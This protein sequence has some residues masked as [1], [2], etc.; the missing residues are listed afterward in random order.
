MSSVTQQLLRAQKLAKSGKFSKAELIYKSLTAPPKNDLSAAV[1]YAIFL[2]KFERWNDLKALWQHA[3]SHP[4]ASVKM[5][6][7][8]ANLHL[9]LN[10]LTEATA[11]V[12]RIEGMN[13]LDAKV[14]ALRYSIAS[15][16]GKHQEALR[17]ALEAVK[18]EPKSVVGFVN[19]GVAFCD[20]A[21]LQQGETAFKIALELEPGNITAL[22]NLGFICAEQ[23]N[24]D[25]SIKYYEQALEATKVHKGIQ[26]EVIEFPLSFQ[27]LSCGRFTEGWMLYDSG[28]HVALKAS[29]RRTPA[30]Y[31]SVPK[32]SGEPLAKKTLLVWREQGLGDELRFSSCLDDVSKLCDHVIVECDPRLVKIFTRSFPNMTIRPAAWDFET[33]KTDKTDFDVHIPIGSLPRYLRKNTESFYPLKSYLIPYSKDISE[34][35][36]VF[37]STLPKG[38]RIGICWRSGNLNPTRNEFYNNLVD[39]VDILRTP[40]CV[41]VNL[42]YGNPEAEILNAEKALGIKIHRWD[43]L[44]LKNDLDGVFA[45]MRNLDLVITVGT[46]VAAMAPLVGTTTWQLLPK[47]HWTE[48]NAKE[49]LWSDKMTILHGDGKTGID[50]AMKRAYQKLLEWMS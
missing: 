23:Q 48:F 12:D 31:F 15:A 33:G 7:Q 20:L 43:D 11:V 3:C 44:D 46:A 8:L 36:H 41:F 21:M 9:R 50:L 32:W 42:Q 22:I 6:S 38:K 27:Y 13:G 26:K 47:K 18:V 1:D 28:F 40:G 39:W 30:R 37:E 5:L 29:S 14:L 24:I 45:L 16:D 49:W 35:K 4:R 10:E 2:E 19:L 17:I 34:I 25:A